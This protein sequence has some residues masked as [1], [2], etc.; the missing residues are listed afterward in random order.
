MNAQ[1]LFPRVKDLKIMDSKTRGHQLKV[2]GEKFKRDIRGNFFQ[3]EGNLY[4]ECA[5][6]RCYGNR[7]NYDFKDTCK[8]I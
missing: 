1:S 2:R 5:A 6:R 3:L 8:G 7:Y 4:L